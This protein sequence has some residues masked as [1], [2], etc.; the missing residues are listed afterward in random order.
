MFLAG[1][2]F[3]GVRPWRL[4]PI[5]SIFELFT[6]RL[7]SVD[8]AAMQRARIPRL[9]AQGPVKLEL[10]NVSQEIPRV[11]NVAGYVILGAGIEIGFGRP[12]ARSLGISNET[13]TTLCCSR[14]A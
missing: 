9:L 4:W 14:R 2:D 6:G 11:R 1:Q 13:P 3:Q 10:L 5:A 12:A 7:V 8:R